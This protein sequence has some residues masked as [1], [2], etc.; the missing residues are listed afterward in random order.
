MTALIGVAFVIFGIWLKAR[1]EERFLMAEL[2]Q[3][4]YGSYCRR[5]PM[6][7]PFLVSR[8]CLQ[9]KANFRARADVQDQRLGGA[10]VETAPSL[11]AVGG[12]R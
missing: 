4:V 8:C 1:T 5:I 7:V 3:E 6:L 11:D 12:L 10:W 9:S 2:G